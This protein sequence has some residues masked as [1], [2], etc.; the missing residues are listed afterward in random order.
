MVIGEMENQLEKHEP[1]QTLD[2]CR[3]CN[4]PF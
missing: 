1:T 2:Y 3:V 4:Y